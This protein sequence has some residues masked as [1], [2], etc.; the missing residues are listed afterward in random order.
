M[1]VQSSV[2][3][4]PFAGKAGMIAAT[5]N[6]GALSTLK[7][8]ATVGFGKAVC[9]LTFPTVGGKNEIGGLVAAATDITGTAWRGIAVF[10]A[11][12]ASLPSSSIGYAQY[13]EVTYIKQGRVFAQYDSASTAPGKDTGVYV[14]YATPG[15]AD[16]TIIGAISGTASSNETALLPRAKFVG[17]VLTDPDGTYIIEIELL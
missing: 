12:K 11:G 6:D 15:G 1:T 9:C 7:A 8:A 14:R 5:T 16:G 4:G 13:D 2:L 10:L 3:T 17:P